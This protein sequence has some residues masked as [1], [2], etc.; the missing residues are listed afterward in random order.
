MKSISDWLGVAFSFSAMLGRIGSTSPIPMN[1]TIAA[2]AI[3]HT[4]AGCPRR[5][6][7]AVP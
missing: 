7:V 1:E 2:N 5:A 3:A 6:A 4:A